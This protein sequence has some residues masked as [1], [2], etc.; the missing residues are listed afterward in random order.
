MD[1]DK[2]NQTLRSKRERVLGELTWYQFKKYQA[3]HQYLDALSQAQ[4][5]TITSRKKTRRLIEECRELS[6]RINNCY[7]LLNCTRD[8]IEN[9]EAA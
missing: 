7:E 5:D 3:F 8:E 4:L 6:E 9:R 2:L 1:I